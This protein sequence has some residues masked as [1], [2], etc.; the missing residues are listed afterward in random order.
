MG[1]VAVRAK[2][3]DELRDG[4][5]AAVANGKTT[6]VVVEVAVEPRVPDYGWWDVPVA[7]VSESETVRAARE[8][9]Q[10]QLANERRR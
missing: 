7:E 9:Y 4:L 5:A 6:V 10:R 2:S 1:A 8:E 3:L